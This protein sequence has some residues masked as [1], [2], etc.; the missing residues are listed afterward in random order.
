M[1]VG[2]NTSQIENSFEPYPEF[3]QKFWDING[4]NKLTKKQDPI[5]PG[6]PQEFIPKTS[7]IL[8]ETVRATLDSKLPY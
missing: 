6:E 5:L 3:K 7:F 2:R 4:E 8:S 1:S